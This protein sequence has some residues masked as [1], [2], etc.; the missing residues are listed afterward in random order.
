M[1][2]PTQNPPSF[3]VSF[4]PQLA[5]MPPE[6]QTVFRSI[7]N[8]LTDIY[9]AIPLLK[10]QID[11]KQTAS[12]SSSTSSSASGSTPTTA[13]V[14]EAI[15]AAISSLQSSILAAFPG[16]VNNQTGVTS[17]STQESDDGKL[18]I[19]NDASPIAISLS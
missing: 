5:S 2:T 12:T 16:G 14:N 4:E 8:S 6:H 17:Y 10:S 11:T 7:F 19:L 1:T 3:R 13:S 9:S 15:S 18:I